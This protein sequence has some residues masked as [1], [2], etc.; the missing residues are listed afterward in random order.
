MW[1]YEEL[2][3]LMTSWFTSDIHLGHQSI[4]RYCPKSRPFAS[5]EEMNEA[6]IERWNKKVRQ[7]DTVY[8]LGDFSFEK[9]PAPSFAR[10]Q[11][12]KRLITG[13]HDANRKA[14]M[15]LPWESIHDLY[16][17]KEN[18]L[19][20]VLCHFPLASWHNAHHGYL[21]FHGHTH[22]SL[23]EQIPHRFDVGF[24]V[25]PDG[26]M[27]FEELAAMAATQEFRPVDH[28]GAD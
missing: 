1:F 18:G 11:G 14:V 16:T 2:R 20:A 9:D 7:Q 6:I 13:N 26:P 22:G 8:F 17:V 10:L 24:D 23:K 3:K 4:L 25:F 12:H 21:H 5:V 19:R 28:H 15:S 27:S